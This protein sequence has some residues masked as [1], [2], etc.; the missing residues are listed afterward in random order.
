MLDL[1]AGRV[2]HQKVKSA[3]RRHT[4][5]HIPDLP[6]RLI[7]LDPLYFSPYSVKLH[8]SYKFSARPAAATSIKQSVIAGRNDGGHVSAS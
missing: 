8:I 7:R 2:F 4:P 1:A 3:Q 6:V 5:V